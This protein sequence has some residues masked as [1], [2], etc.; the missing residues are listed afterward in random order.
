MAAQDT[1]P[2]APAPKPAAKPLPDDGRPKVGPADPETRR[3][4]LDKKL[5][6][7]SKA[8]GTVK[9]DE[10]QKKKKKRSA[11]GEFTDALNPE[12]PREIRVGPDGKPLDDMATAIERGIKEAKDHK[13]D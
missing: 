8:E 4:E 10:P 12:V 6:E 5:N 11:T 9:R 7:P 3:K 1:K 2:K 13:E